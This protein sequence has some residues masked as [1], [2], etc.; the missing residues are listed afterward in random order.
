[1]YWGDRPPDALY[2]HKL[3]VRRD[4]AGRGIGAAIVEWANAEAAGSGTRVPPARLPLR[5]Q[6]AHPRL[7]RRPGLRAPRRPRPRRS[8]HEPVRAPGPMSETFSVTATDGAA[9]GRPAHRARR[10]ADAGVHAGR[11]EGDR[12]DAWIPTSCARSARTILLGNTYHLHFRPGEDLIAGARRPASLHGLGRADPHRLRRLPGLL[13]ARHDRRGRRRRRH[14]PLGLRR[15]CRALHARVGRARSRR[16][17]APTSRCASTS[18]RPPDVPRAELAEAV[19][20]TTLWAARQLRRARAPRAS[21]SSGSRRV[22]PIRSCAAARSQRSP[23][24]A[25][26]ATR[27]AGSRSARSAA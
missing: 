7:L 27:S 9:R 14:V 3:A 13:A 25:S 15:R 26:T 19:R 23:S 20:P 2:V 22:R 24:S 5:R 18:V 12:Q 8:E 16:S 6:P 4:R 10:G 11:D 21:S 17:S 1:M